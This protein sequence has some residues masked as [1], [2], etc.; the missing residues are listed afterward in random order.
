M[1][2]V[3]DL[4]IPRKCAGCG[5]Q[6]EIFCRQCVNASYTPRTACLFCGQR[7]LM[8]EVCVS[9]RRQAKTP[10]KRVFWAGRYDGELKKAVWALKYGKRRETAK[11]LGE[12]LARK[13]FSIT[14]EAE[15]FSSH[16]TLSTG[17][18]TRI[19]K[20]SQLP[21][22]LAKPPGKK[23]PSLKSDFPGKSDFFPGDFEDGGFAVIPI[24][25]HFKKQ[26]ERGFNQAE[27]L[28]R[29][30]CKIT[31]L[32]L[33]TDVL[34]KTKETQEQ[35]KVENKELRLTNMED[36]FEVSLGNPIAKRLNIILIDDVSTTGATLTHA[37]NALKNAGAKNII[38]LVVAHG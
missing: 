17:A 26:Y 20:S 25:L 22:F 21:H 24:P 16:L 8:G 36:A 37:A 35:V 14:L 13:F 6:A 28:A 2:K 34:Q 12:L 18:P 10:L 33:L 3:L 30:F 23:S 19:Q 27:L 11:P 5:M 15:I 4:I 38:G 1:D 9:C 7:N 32:P 29:E 31:G